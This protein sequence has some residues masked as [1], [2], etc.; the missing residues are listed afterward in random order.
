MAKS[1]CL[2]LKGTDGVHCIVV[3]SCDD[4]IIHLQFLQVDT[5]RGDKKERE[6]DSEV[7]LP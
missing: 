1:I 4:I 2:L 3:V 5:G 6:E 7:G